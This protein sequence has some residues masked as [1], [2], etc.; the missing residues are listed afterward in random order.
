[1]ETTLEM[2]EIKRVRALGLEALEEDKDNTNRDKLVLLKLDT[3][4]ELEEIRHVRS[5][6]LEEQEEAAEKAR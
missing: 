4:K 1:M 6:A 3:T 5:R 2:E